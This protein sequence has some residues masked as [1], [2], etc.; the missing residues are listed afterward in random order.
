MA[1]ELE[2]RDLLRQQRDQMLKL[3]TRGFYNELTSFGVEP[4][5]LLRVASHLIDNLMAGKEP[6]ENGNSFHN[7]MFNLG[8]VRNDWEG[9][10]TL[11][12]K[13]VVLRPLEPPTLPRVAGWLADRTVRESFVPAFPETEAE[14]HGHFSR[15]T[16]RYLQILYAG[17]PVGIVGG[18]DIDEAA[19]K[20]AMKK[21][22]GEGRMRGKGIGKC[23]TFGFLYYAFMILGMNKVYIHSRDI[24]I[25]NINL[26]SRF[27]FELEGIFYEDLL[28]NGMRSDVVRMALLKRS[29]LEVFTAKEGGRIGNIRTL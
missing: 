6:A 9:S 13:D 15:P 17:E 22:V 26:N 16:S 4:K 18:E 20:L 23:A 8:T 19:G 12:V 10:Q 27:G 11:T 2:E 1:E 29:W 21:L 5:E 7:G 28:V 24:N 3:V 14:L 25:R